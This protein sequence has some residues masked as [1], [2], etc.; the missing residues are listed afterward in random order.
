MPGITSRQSLMASST[1]MTCTEV[2]TKS[3]TSVDFGAD[4]RRQKGM[5]MHKA[6]MAGWGYTRTRRELPSGPPF[7][8]ST[9][10]VPRAA[11]RL[12]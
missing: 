2:G 6:E 5:V 11:A 4:L 7:P 1:G 10:F 12:S 3:P 9:L 8:R